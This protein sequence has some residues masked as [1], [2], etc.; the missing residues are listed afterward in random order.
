M[1]RDDCVH[2]EVDVPC[3]ESGYFGGACTF[4][5]CQ[6][7]SY[8]RRRY[9]KAPSNVGS[10]LA[11]L[12]GAMDQKRSVDRTHLQACNILDQELLY[13]FGLCKLIVDDDRWD[14]LNTEQA[15]CERSALP[16]DQQKVAGVVGRKANGD[17]R[18]NTELLDR[19]LKLTM[20]VSVA[21]AVQS[22]F[23][24]DARNHNIPHD[25]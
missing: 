17:R 1:P 24:S 25:E 9:A 12:S 5:L 7:A 10:L 4:E 20:A 18:Q 3:P 8:R 16:F 14:F 2:P 11:A 21:L 15:A 22:G 19:S 23:R 13:F 6:Q